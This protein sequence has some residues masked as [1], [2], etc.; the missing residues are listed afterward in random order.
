[1]S[2][3]YW[4]KFERGFNAM[5]RRERAVSLLAVLALIYLLWTLILLAPVSA[6]IEKLRLQKQT[7]DNRI[8]DLEAQER[9]YRQV[10]SQDPNAA[11]KREMNHLQQRLE[12]LDKELQAL[13]VGLVPAERLPQVLH[14]VIPN[15]GDL[16]LLGLQTLPV[17]K[18]TITGADTATN[19]GVQM[20]QAHQQV[21]VYRHTVE[22]KVRGSYFT[23]AEY[24]KQLEALPWRFYWDKL[25]YQVDS[26][27]QA[28]ATMQV[29]TLSAGEGLLGE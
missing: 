6:N 21:D 18:L 5:A 1:M 26:Y 9:V 23:V 17:Q 22:L 15:T 12:A 28:I 13:A 7:L 3:P 16:M 19:E 2:D 4:R 8:L 24:L 14:D 20:V 27:P 10:A 25:D 29:Y 11:S